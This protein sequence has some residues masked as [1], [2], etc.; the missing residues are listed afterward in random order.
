VRPGGR[1]PP[2]VYCAIPQVLMSMDGGKS[3]TVDRVLAEHGLQRQV[4]VTVP[5][6]QA[7]ALTIAE[8]GLLGSLPIH[9]ARPVAALLGLDLYLPPFDPPIIDVVLFWHRRV[10]GNAANAWLRDH[11]AEAM[12]FGP[13]KV[14]VPLAV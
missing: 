7:V 8:S 6:F 11:I 4:A 10:D 3:G 9:F 14:T 2:D 13:A 5:H 1:I 12:D